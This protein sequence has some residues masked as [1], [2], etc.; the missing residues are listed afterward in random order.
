MAI[1]ATN[2]LLN[3]LSGR[4][5]K[6]MVFKMLRGKTIVASRPLAPT[7]QSEQ[8]RANRNKFKQASEWAKAE[9]IHPGKKEYYEDIGRKLRLP[10]AYTAAIKVYMR[11]DGDQILADVLL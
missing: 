6:N 7:R 3:G 8:Q 1:V 5:G 2:P 11:A 9:L 10:N 4:L